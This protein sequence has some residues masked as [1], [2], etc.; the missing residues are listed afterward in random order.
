MKTIMERR[1]KYQIAC[2]EVSINSDMKERALSFA[3]GIV[4]S[5]NQYSRLLPDNIR[6]SK[7]ISMQ[8][9]IEVQRTYMGKLG[10][11]SFAMCLSEKGKQVDTDGMFEIYE[12]QTNVDEFDFTTRDGKSVDVKTGFRPIH[13]RLMINIEQFNNIPKD[14][15]VAVKLNATDVNPWDK[16]VDWNN[17]TTATILGYADHWYIEK[18]AAI[19]DFGEGRARWLWYDKLMGIE[20]LIPLL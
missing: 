2:Y 5:D 14:Y 16:I 13:K 10:E 8:Q 3:N 6:T 17:I 11:M 15:Y 20:N 12:G 18:H 4:L 9:K 19:Y 1:G 7:D